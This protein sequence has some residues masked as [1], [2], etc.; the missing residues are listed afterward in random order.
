MFQRRECLKG[1]VL[2]FCLAYVWAAAHGYPHPLLWG[3]TLASIPLSY[4][5]RPLLQQIQ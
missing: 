3:T 2:V 1:S 4:A 5:T